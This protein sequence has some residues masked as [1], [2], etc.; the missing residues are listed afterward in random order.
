MQRIPFG[1][2]AKENIAQM[3][4]VKKGKNGVLGELVAFIKSSG[5]NLPPGIARIV[6][7]G[8]NPE[9]PLKQSLSNREHMEDPKKLKVQL[10]D[11]QFEFKKL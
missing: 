8:A 7:Q 10:S 9:S 1:E 2:P 3:S 4:P 5:V 11:L 6:G